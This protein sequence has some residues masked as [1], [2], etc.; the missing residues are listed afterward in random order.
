MAQSKSRE[1]VKVTIISILS[2]ALFSMGFMI[3]NNRVFNAATLGTQLLPQL[4]GAEDAPT[5]LLNIDD[6]DDDELH[7]SD[8]DLET[9]LFEVTP[10][11]E[12]TSAP[13]FVPPNLTVT[14]IEFQKAREGYL[15]DYIIPIEE[16]AQLGALYI[17]DIYGICIDGLYVEMMYAAWPSTARTYWMGTV[18]DATDFQNID[19]WAHNNFRQ[20]R[21]MID[22]VTGMRVDISR[23]YPIIPLTDGDWE[24]MLTWRTEITSFV[25]NT[26]WH[27]IGELERM[28]HL[29]VTYEDIRPYLQLAR[30]YAARHFN[31][32][33]VIFET[34]TFEVMLPFNR[35]MV[36]MFSIDD[37]PQVALGGIQYSVMDSTG[38]EASV[39]ISF[40]SEGYNVSITT[41]FNDIVPGYRPIPP[42][43][44]EGR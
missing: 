39:L 7:I 25:E 12:V 11:F 27:N 18:S 10:L 13:V 38:R 29:G 9:Y 2:V 21:F 17:W 31:D 20:F 23:D 44:T 34:G 8:D 5:L 32:S 35:F 4:P 33:Y 16:A 41:Q 15:P 30:E 24:D 40:M 37:E 19:I 1:F 43:I 6:E 42:L 28:R 36:P 14:H 3:V 22:A 26:N